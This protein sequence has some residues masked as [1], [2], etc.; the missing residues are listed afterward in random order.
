LQRFRKAIAILIVI[1]FI[2]Q[3]V[4]SAFIPRNKE[5]TV[6]REKRFGDYVVTFIVG[7]SSSPTKQPIVGSK[8][9]FGYDFETLKREGVE[10]VYYLSGKEFEI[11]K[12]D[13]IIN[14]NE[15]F[16]KY[17]E[18]KKRVPNTIAG[19]IFSEPGTYK[20]ISNFEHNGKI[21]TTEFF[22]EVK[23]KEKYEEE[24]V[25]GTLITIFSFIMVVIFAIYLYE[26]LEE[27]KKKPK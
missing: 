14:N 2:I 22:V 26:K 13:K 15:D 25:K 5:S 1:L 16:K 4:I 6:I 27:P 24:S 21:I 10:E 8:V 19:Y 3:F 23:T 20:I 12:D 11:K 7:T 9:F 17:F 18:N